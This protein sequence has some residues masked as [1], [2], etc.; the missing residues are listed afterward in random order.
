M[1]TSFFII[2]GCTED[3]VATQAPAVQIEPRP[4]KFVVLHPPADAG[5]RWSDETAGLFT[6]LLE[7]GLADLSDVVPRRAQG[8]AAI[9]LDRALRHEALT[10]RAELTLTGSPEALTFQVALCQDGCSYLSAQSTREDPVSAVARLLPELAVLLR[11]APVGGS[12]EHWGEALSLDPYAQLMTGRGAAAIYGLRA[13]AIRPGHD[14]SDPVARA[15]LIDPANPLAEWML[16]R[17]NLALGD[18]AK[19]RQNMTRGL[20]GRRGSVAL[21]A[22]EATLLGTEGHWAASAEAWAQA[23]ADPEVGTR[24][25]L[26]HAEALLMAGRADEA[27]ALLDRLH[28]AWRSE[29]S[30]ASLRVRIADA[31]PPDPG[32]DALLAEWQEAELGNPEPVRR[33]IGLRVR[34]QD[35]AGAEA[36][37]PE[38]AERGAALESHQLGAALAVARGDL[39]LAREHA[40]G[41]ADP[42]LMARLAEP[43]L[44][45][46][47]AP[48]PSL[49]LAAACSALDRGDPKEALR[50]LDRLLAQE[51]LYVEAEALRV[52]AL[53]ALGRP[54]LDAE[55]RL[56]A[57]E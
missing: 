21:L 48:S 44:G 47:D 9:G 53:A 33:R 6:A 51:P 56:A 7:L 3:P 49:R 45:L 23:N 35:W 17:R 8:R 50:L 12:S 1:A 34:D 28:G 30:V 38:L 25:I 37:L 20:A 43:P 31:L 52:Q 27:R 16:G 18:P 40:L 26:P 29:D 39:A 55:K 42:E 14:R 19:A 41:S 13:D 22:A 57:L 4:G 2:M 36:L 10:W 32:Y 54:T 24:F 11:S 15:V 46:A 5:F